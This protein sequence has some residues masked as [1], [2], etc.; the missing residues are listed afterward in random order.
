L[1]LRDGYGVVIGSL[2][3]YYPDP[4]EGYGDYYHANLDVLT[5]HGIYRCKIDVD[6][7]DSAGVMWRVAELGQSDLNGVAKLP[8]GWH[9]LD[10][11]R[12]SG[13]LDYLRSPELNPGQSPSYVVVDPTL[14]LV[15]RAL[16]ALHAPT[17][18]RG[19]TEQAL[20]DIALLLEDQTRIF[21]FGEPFTRGRGVHNVHQNQGDPLDSEW[22]AENGIW[23]D[24]ALVVRRKAGSLTAYLAKY[25]TQADRTDRHGH[26]A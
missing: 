7:K 26:P 8:D 17:W 9:D 20:A 13:A 15:R 1:P 5:P 23:Q 25:P 21:V 12:H 24:G 3:R 6:G 14:E 4:P 19:S 22:S 11:T 2:H 10:S 16:G 18:R